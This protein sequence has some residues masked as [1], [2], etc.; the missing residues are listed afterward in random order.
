MLSAKR[1]HDVLK[2]S[3]RAVSTTDK[4]I[5]G[6]CLLLPTGA[7]LSSYCNESSKFAI[8]SKLKMFSLYAANKFVEQMEHDEIEVGAIGKYEVEDELEI[9]I[10]SIDNVEFLVLLVVEKG[11]PAGLI[12]LK[13]RQLKE[14]LRGL[15][16]YDYEG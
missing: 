15:Q 7:I 16:D 3:V 11:Y 8:E 5:V 2:Q 1:I 13:L 4:T 6:S 9:V 10:S 14:V 12:R